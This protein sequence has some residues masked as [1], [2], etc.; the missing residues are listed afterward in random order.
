MSS[1]KSRALVV[2]MMAS[3]SF[4]VPMG[5]LVIAPMMEELLQPLGEGRELLEAMQASIAS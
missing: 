5:E 4:Y 2:A 3:G 1:P